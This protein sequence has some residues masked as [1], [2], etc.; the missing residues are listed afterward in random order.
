VLLYRK[1]RV[2]KREMDTWATIF[3]HE[4]HAAERND[5]RG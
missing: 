5:I 4:I 3:Y 1:A 2:L